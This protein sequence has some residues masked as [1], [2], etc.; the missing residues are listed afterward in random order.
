VKKKKEERSM[1]P[2]A[3]RTQIKS[4]GWLWKIP[5]GLLILLLIVLA[6]AVLSINTI[7]HKQIN[8]AMKDMLTE[9]GSLEA[10]DIGL[11]AGRVELNGL[12]VNPPKDHGTDPLLSMG[13]LVLDVVPTSLLSDVIVVEEVTLKGMSI[14]LVRDK[15]GRLGL[16]KLV[17]AE[18]PAP[19]KP[20]AAAKEKTLPVVQ[21]NKFRLEDGSI[22]V[23][24]SALT[25]KPMVFPL[26][27][28]HVAVD[29]LRL[30]EENKG[31]DPA[32]VSV[33]FQLKQPGKLPAAHFG[34]VARLG[35]VGRGVPACNAHARMIGLKLATLGALIPPATRTA[36]GGDGLDSGMA[37]ALNDGRIKL[38][39]A[40]MTDRNIRY[41]TIK[42]RGPLNAPKVEIA[43][44]LSGVFRVTD[45]VLNLG[46][47]GL[48]AG[49]SIAG[50]G[51][52]VAKEMGTGALN[53][54][55]KLLGGLFDT[56][57]GLATLDA[58]QVEKGLAGSTVGTI[59]L[60]LG[61]LGGAGSAAGGGVDKSVSDLTGEA[62]LKAW[63]KAIPTRYQTAMQE[64]EKAL[65]KMPYPPVTQ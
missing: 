1:N 51:V 6:V 14:N 43:P 62:A 50:G 22:T 56:G 16:D 37:L 21:V 49:I 12:T 28:I 24:D 19:E 27:D 17:K 2:H 3:S 41:D 38:D 39:A 8:R 18:K 29:Q 40:A 33:S 65:A 11:L 10:I 15:Q 58:K 59:D 42:V 9:G 30:F 54:G 55:K 35:P 45:G 26:T 20:D 53:V 63:N 25:G 32:A 46:K 34:T 57:K 47:S 4:R 44:I 31:G 36:L 64:A 61:A 52:N 23:R 48:G 5:L 60:S 13:N 7:A